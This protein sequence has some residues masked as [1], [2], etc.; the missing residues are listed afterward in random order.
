[1]GCEVDC[2]A[3][4]K[5]P[6]LLPGAPALAITAS[7]SLRDV[8]LTEAEFCVVASAV[9]SSGAGCDSSGKKCRFLDLAGDAKL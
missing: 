3:A 1:M 9:D 6:M 2:P 8:F 4:N 5:V 7:P